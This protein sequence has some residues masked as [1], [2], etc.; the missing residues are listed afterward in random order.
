M[1]AGA[2]V[3]EGTRKLAD[4][5]IPAAGYEA[6]EL[7]LRILD[8][9]LAGYLLHENE[10][11]LPDM[12]ERYRSAAGR[13]ATGE[14]LQYI[15]GMAPFYGRDF[16]VRE[17]VLIPRFDTETLIEEVLPRLSTG[18]TILDLC[19]GSGCILL[20]LLLEG[21]PGLT[22]VGSD[23]YP[24]A[25]SA[26]CENG[27]KFA[28]EIRRKHSAAA[29]VKSD[30]FGAI[31]DSYDIICSNPP[32]IRRDEVDQLDAEV[33]EYEPRTALDGGEDGLD[34]YRLICREAPGHLRD[35]GYLALEIGYDEAEAVASLL[36]ENGFTEVRITCDLGGRPRV[37]GGVKHG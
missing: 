14:P 25:L 34:F 26:A 27:R 10:P 23:L 18:K 36:A 31:P 6:R 16:A 29:F 1:T 22:G 2:L 9:D 17:G 19:T 8:L 35:G 4:A 12:E 5:G 28:E 7:M 20:T 13:R 32:Y 30:L 37:A 24:E 3:R 21:P 15:T 33:A 11:V